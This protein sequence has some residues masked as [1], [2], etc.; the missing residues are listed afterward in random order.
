MKVKSY[1]IWLKRWLMETD[2]TL[3]RQ[4]PI[5]STG[6]LPVVTSRSKRK[7]LTIAL[8]RGKKV[9]SKYVFT[10]GNIYNFSKSKLGFGTCFSNILLYF[11]RKMSFT[12]AFCAAT[13]F[14]AIRTTKRVVFYTFSYS[15]KTRKSHYWSHLSALF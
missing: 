11:C 15:V 7:W 3:R 14:H 13:G 8:Q 6:L 10:I 12:L 2:L 9:K 5:S 4:D 1:E